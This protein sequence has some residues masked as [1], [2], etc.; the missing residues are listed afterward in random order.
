MR[1]LVKG[2]AVM[3][4]AV[5]AAGCGSTTST[6]PRWGYGGPPPLYGYLDGY[7]EDQTATGPVPSWAW[8]TNIPGSR[9]YSSFRGVPE[10]WYTFPGPAGP[11]GEPGVMGPAGPAGPVGPAGPRGPAGAPGIA[12]TPGP[13]GAQG[14]AGLPGPPG[15]QGGQGLRVVE[16]R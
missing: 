16:A 11:P 9:R 15:P 3:T 13:V 12:G 1:H 2:L 10:Q 6:T 8:G 4:V 14:A 5:V 7:V